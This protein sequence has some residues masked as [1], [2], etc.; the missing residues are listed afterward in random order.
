MTDIEYDPQ[1]EILRKAV[2][3]IGWLLTSY[4]AGRITAESFRVGVE[5]I[6]NVC[7]G[8]IRLQSFND[9]M[10]DANA[11]LKTLPHEPKVTVLQKVNRLLITVT[12]GT[13]ANVIL[14]EVE[15]GN[16]TRF[17]MEDEAIAFSRTYQEKGA[18]KG[19]KGMEV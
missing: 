1:H 14:A 2:N 11:E 15:A 9:L 3:Q 8:V 4:E 7:G 19:F 12:D 6:W 18:A 17:D 13:A 10:T 5:T 16:V